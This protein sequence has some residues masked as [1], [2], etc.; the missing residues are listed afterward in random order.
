MGD[1]ERPEVAGPE[2]EEVNIAAA[3]PRVHGHPGQWHT[4]GAAGTGQGQDRCGEF[5]PLPSETLRRPGPEPS[6]QPAF[7][8]S[9]AQ[10]AVPPSPPGGVGWEPGFCC[11]ALHPGPDRAT[12]W[13]SGRG[14]AH[15]LRDSPRVR[16]APG[17]L[18]REIRGPEPAL[19]DVAEPC[20]PPGGCGS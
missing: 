17:D 9:S 18:A 19:V 8:L 7:A 2:L 3:F 20:M 12:L 16:P 6:P 15:P 5:Y 10:E 4:Q 13:G 1:P 14:E 11:P